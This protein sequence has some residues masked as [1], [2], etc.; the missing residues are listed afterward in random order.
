MR[1]ASFPHA[2]GPLHSYILATNLKLCDPARFVY[3]F[4]IPHLVDDG[5]DNDDIVMVTEVNIEQVVI[6]TD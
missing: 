4:S 6:V 3:P 5:D 2:S 1:L